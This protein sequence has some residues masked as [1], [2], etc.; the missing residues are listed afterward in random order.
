[1]NLGFKEQFI[2]KIIDGT[3][4]HTIR[5]D[6]PNRW[7]KGAII[8]FATGVRTKNYNCFKRGICLSTQTIEFKWQNYN[9]ALVSEGWSVKVFIDGRDVTNDDIIDELAVNDGFADRKAF[10]EW[11]AWYKKDFKGKIIHWTDLKY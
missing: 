2:P 8:H 6:K 4:K 3:K 11:E 7:G 9:K 5:D 1:M 10:F